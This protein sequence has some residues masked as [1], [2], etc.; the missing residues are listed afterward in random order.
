MNVNLELGIVLLKWTSQ[1]LIAVVGVWGLVSDPF[2]TDAASGR[3]RLNRAG[4]LKIVLMAIGFLLFALTDA[5]ERRAAEAQRQRQ[6]QQIAMQRQTVAA[7]DTQLAYLRKLILLQ[8]RMSELGLVLEFPKNVMREM[9]S[10]IEGYQP[11]P[12]QLQA[13]RTQLAYIA[14]AMRAGTAVVRF[15]G[16]GRGE[17]QYSLNRPQGLTGGRITE[18]EPAWAAFDGAFR[19]LFGGRFEMMSESGRTLVDL[20][21]PASRTSV[22]FGGNAVSF[23]VREPEVRLDE[24]SGT[25][26]F[27][28][29]K[30]DLLFVMEE[31][32][33]GGEEAQARMAEKMHFGPVKARL[34]S[35]DPRVQWDQKIQLD[36]RPVISRRI[37][38][39]DTGRIF[40][41]G[42]W[43]SGPSP[44]QA[45]FSRLG[46]E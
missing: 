41:L 14:A 20:V 5:N 34:T 6:E 21:N 15:D 39:T 35:K 12:P 26:S 42:E 32:F 9:W 7:Q 1:V 33:D 46:F 25:L 3:R 45:T 38:E 23:S 30:D 28:C 24:L 16:T 17:L 2:D 29:G 37:G 4:W 19:A 44:V 27:V 31:A 11:K 18:S 36:W 43:H 22:T 10:A 8:Y 40:E 13:D